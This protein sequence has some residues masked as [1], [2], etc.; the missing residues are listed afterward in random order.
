L[1]RNRCP[2]GAASNQSVPGTKNGGWRT[3]T[4]NR[5]PRISRVAAVRRL[6]GQCSRSP[7]R[8]AAT[9]ATARLHSRPDSVRSTCSRSPGRAPRRRFRGNRSSV[10]SELAIDLEE[11]RLDERIR[12]AVSGERQQPQIVIGGRAL[13]GIQQEPA[14]GC[15]VAGIL[16][17][18]RIEQQCFSAST[19]GGPLVHVVQAGARV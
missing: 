8:R 14:V 19:V 3:P 2:S 17:L 10:W 9:S 7:C 16:V 4:W 11:R 13:L 15:H 5:S 12:L 1:T 6:S 18:R